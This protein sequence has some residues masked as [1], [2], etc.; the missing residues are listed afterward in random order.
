MVHGY[1]GVLSFAF[2]YGGVR[3]CPS[4]CHAPFEVLTKFFGIFLAQKS[5]A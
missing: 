2:L 4:L 3:Y 1:S 5:P